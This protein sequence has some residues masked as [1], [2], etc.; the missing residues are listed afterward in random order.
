MANE[1]GK[2]ISKDE[3]LKM[4]NRYKASKK[5]VTESVYF[6][7]STFERLLAEPGTVGVRVYYGLN[8]KDELKPIFVPVNNAGKNILVSHKSASVSAASA[9]VAEESTIEDY[10]NPCPPLCNPP[11]DE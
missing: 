4:R 11:G 7:R 5:F 6:D 10:G 3:M 2:R 1:N 9:S 8:E